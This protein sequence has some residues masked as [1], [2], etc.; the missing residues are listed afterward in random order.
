MP[1]LHD[2]GFLIDTKDIEYDI[3][4]CQGRGACFYTKYQPNLQYDLL[5]DGLEIPHKKWLFDIIDNYCETEL[6]KINTFYSHENTVRF[7]LYFYDKGNTH[8]RIEK[9]LEKMSDYA[10]KKRYDLSCE[11][12]NRLTENWE[13]YMSDDFIENELIENEYYF[14]DDLNIVDIDSIENDGQ[15]NE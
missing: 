10:E 3:N 8:S 12:C 1:I 6:K 13:N 14:D 7:N 2:N 5:F 4:Y 9:I 15:K 11:I